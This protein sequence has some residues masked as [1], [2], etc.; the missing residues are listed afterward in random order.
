MYMYTVHSMYMYMYIII[1]MYMYSMY[2]VYMYVLTNT[3]MFFF[4][5]DVGVTWIAPSSL[6]FFRTSNASPVF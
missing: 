6:G 5:S 2:R 1:Y 4:H 3:H